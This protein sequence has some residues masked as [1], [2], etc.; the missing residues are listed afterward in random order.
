MEIGGFQFHG[1]GARGVIVFGGAVPHFVA[2]FGNVDA[3]VVE[4]H[5]CAE[6]G[7]AGDLLVFAAGVDTAVVCAAGL[8]VQT[9]AI[10]AKI[11][12]QFATA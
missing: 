9:V 12:H 3:D 1:D 4:T 11:Q 7:F 5:V 8:V 2:E 10:L 6:G